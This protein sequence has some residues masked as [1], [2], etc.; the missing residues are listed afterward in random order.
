MA[1]DRLDE[2]AMRL[3]EARLSNQT[4]DHLPENCR[5]RDKTEAYAIQ[6]LLHTHLEAGGR[7]RLIGRKIGCTTPV[8]QRYLN[9]DSPCA[10]GLFETCVVESGA[11]LPHHDFRRVGV[12]CEIAVRL[13][14]DL[15]PLPDGHR[16]D[17]IGTAVE[18]CMAAIEI[19]DDR[20]VDYRSLD[21][22]TLIADDFFNAGAVLG[23][24]VR[25]FASLD[26][27]ALE[28]RMIVDGETVGQGVGAAILGHPLKALAWLANAEN[29]RGRSLHAG[30]LVLLGSLVQTQWVNAGS[31]VEIS[32]DG[33]GS[34]SAR[35]E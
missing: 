7:G 19:V 13:A 23:P 30:D 34:T 8:M 10:G 14:T 15:P 25:A 24:E 28:G 21:T 6:A 11:H 9:I 17:T 1:K 12:E 27:A 35:F 29:A 16:R 22:P 26:L 3:A 33:L 18:S 20:Y 5:P 2:A 4:F 31:I 32:V